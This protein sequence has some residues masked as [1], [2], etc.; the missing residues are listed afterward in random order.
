[1][2]YN[3]DIHHRRSIRLR[4][5]DYAQRGAYFVTIVAQSITPR[6]VTAPR[7][8]T[9]RVA[10]TGVT[11]GDHDNTATIPANTGI[12]PSPTW[13]DIMGAFKSMTTHAYVQG[14]ESLGWP[15]FTSRL[16][17]RNYYEHIIRHEHDLEHSRAYIADNPRRWAF[18]HEN[19]LSTKP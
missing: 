15:P 10:P 12:N 8:A 7:R 3:P 5:Y 19:P 9:T 18:D 17:Q 11:V 16:W 1:M 13:G 4:G 2:P 14:V 6:R